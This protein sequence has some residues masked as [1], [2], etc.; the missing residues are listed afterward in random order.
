MVDALSYGQKVP[1]C[2]LVNAT[3]ARNI[4]KLCKIFNSA[5]WSA[6]SKYWVMINCDFQMFCPSQSSVSLS[7][8]ESVIFCLSWYFS[9]PKFYEM[10]FIYS[11]R[12]V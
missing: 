9:E 7:L 2:D 10:T 11:R 5:K 4:V 12:L 8:S 1:Q 6:M 3:L